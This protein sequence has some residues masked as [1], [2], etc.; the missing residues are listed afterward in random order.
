MISL[1]KAR[2]L[3]EAGLKWD[4]CRGDWYFYISRRQFVKYTSEADVI[5]SDPESDNY[6]F[7]PRLDQL[8]GE[9]EKYTGCALYVF[10]NNKYEVEVVD[11]KE[12][13][14][15]FKADTPEDAAADALLWLMGQE[16]K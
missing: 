8:L 4:P 6:T 10:G 11:T 9:I 16:G 13:N 2:A 5:K 15:H 1:E 12:W 7:C 3:K 14:H